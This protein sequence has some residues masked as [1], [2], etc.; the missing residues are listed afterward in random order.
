MR[1]TVSGR[2]RRTDSMGR[3][4]DGNSS[5]ASSLMCKSV[6]P[7]GHSHTTRIHVHRLLDNGC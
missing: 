1:G 4:T 6:W 7:F 2:R 3:C 5:V